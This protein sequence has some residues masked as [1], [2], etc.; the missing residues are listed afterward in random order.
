MHFFYFK[1]LFSR[2]L[3]KKKKKD[4]LFYI[5]LFMILNFLNLIQGY[6]V[7]FDD[8]ILKSSLI[9]FVCSMFDNIE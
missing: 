3:R 4:H 5:D 8:C 7:F 1:T 9:L 2:A 6:D